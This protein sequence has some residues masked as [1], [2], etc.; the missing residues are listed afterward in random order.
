MWLGVSGV[1]AVTTR[2]YG[3]IGMGPGASPPRPIPGL[4]LQ[5]VFSASEY[6]P[7]RS[8]LSPQG[9]AFDASRG[10][11]YVADTGN[12][13]IVVLGK[14]GV[15]VG[16]FAHRVRDQSG[17]RTP[18]EPAGLLSADGGTVWVTDA[19]SDQVDLLDIRGMPLRA[20]DVTAALGRGTRASPGKM[21]ADREGNLYLVERSSGQVLV[22]DR[23]GGL[24][25]AFGRRGKGEGRFEMVADVAVG[26]DGTSYVLDSV[27]TPVVQAFDAQG[28]HLLGFGRHS[29]KAED[30][31]FPVALAVDSK[32]RLWVA[33]T[34]SHE[35]KAYSASGE[36]LGAFGEAGT[37]PGQFFF[38]SDVVTSPDGTLYVLEKAGRRLQAFHMVGSAAPERR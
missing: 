36:F 22:F 2:A 15:P 31:H 16:R 30:F 32:E 1:G 37:G 21:D 13:Q 3:A 4:E 24:A 26:S 17:D 38:P 27:G 23:R 19:L 7:H 9:L 8:F 5:P 34:F 14:N 25:R 35:V 33:D 29:N 12:H 11:I 28:R 20:I 10:E 6:A 18:G